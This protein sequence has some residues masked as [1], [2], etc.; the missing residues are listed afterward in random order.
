MGLSNSTF[1][2]RTDNTWEDCYDHAR[3]ESF[4]EDDAKF[5]ALRCWDQSV[6]ATY[7][8]P[9]CNGALSNDVLEL[10][11]RHVKSPMLLAAQESIVE[12]TNYGFTMRALDFSNPS[13]EWPAVGPATRWKC[14]GARAVIHN[15]NLLLIG[16]GPSVGARFPFDDPSNK[17]PYGQQILRLTSERSGWIAWGQLQTKRSKPYVIS[18]CN[19]LFV[20]SG[21]IHGASENTIEVIQYNNEILQRSVPTYDQRV[22][23][24]ATAACSLDNRAIMIFASRYPSGNSILVYD[25]LDDRWSANQSE[26]FSSVSAVISVNPDDA[27]AIDHDASI[28]PVA[29]NIK[30]FDFR[31]NTTQTCASI[32]VPV[33]N[34]L[35]LNSSTLICV[36]E[37]T[38]CSEFR[39]FDTRA[40]RLYD[41]RINYYTES[42]FPCAASRVVLMNAE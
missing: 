10:I 5:K 30:Q 39:N 42:P 1:F 9:P 15:D 19:G 29:W 11:H 40:A 38:T 37:S 13:R 31:S 41:D 32:N 25:P 27:Y 8:G 23:G 28:S 7:S 24:D 33:Q 34:L 26:L 18:T 6:V 21:S 35:R 3:D 22:L 4:T 20:L 36:S 12:D 14:S 17:A 16:G 2:G